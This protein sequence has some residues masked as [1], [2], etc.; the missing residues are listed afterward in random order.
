MKSSLAKDTEKQYLEPEKV[1]FFLT[2]FPKSKE[3]TKFS[4]IKKKDA[5]VGR[6]QRGRFSLRQ[7]PTLV[8]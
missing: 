5:F 8:V 3:K 4:K 7:R 2:A 1:H 6:K